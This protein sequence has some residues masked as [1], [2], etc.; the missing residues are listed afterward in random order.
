MQNATYFIAPNGNDSNSGRIDSPLATLA[1]ANELVKAGDTIY[2][3]GGTYKPAKDTITYLTKD[4]TKDAPIR[5]FAYQNENP[6]LDASHWTRRT[7]ATGGKQV[8]WQRGDYWHVKGI[9]ITGSSRHG[10]IA[11]SVKGSI[12]EDLNIHDN[13]QTGLGLFGDGTEDNLILGGDFYRN[14]DP[15]R[16]G[17]DAD[18]LGIGQG[19]GK[20]NVIR[21]V[22]AYHNS[23]DGIDLYA[24][25]DNITI[26]NT[27]AFGN[28]IDRW[29][30]GDA[31]D[32]DGAGFRLSS[33]VGPVAEKPDLAHIIRNNLA[34]DN[35]VRGFNYNGSLGTLQI[36]N[37]TS[38]NNGVS[39][40]FNR[41]NHR[42]RNNIAVGGDLQ[43]E[44]ELGVDDANNSWTLPVVANA[45]DF[46]SVDSTAAEGPRQADG[47][48]PDTDFLKLREDS[49]LI[50]AGIEIGLP[51]EGAAPDLGAFEFQSTQRPPVEPI[52][53]YN[54]DNTI[55][56]VV[57]DDS[58][59]GN[60]NS[61]RLING[62]REE[63][64]R[65]RHIVLNGNGQ[66]Q[67][68]NSTDINLGIHEERT[69]SLWFKVNDKS[70]TSRK[71]LLY[72]EGAGV[73]GL[74]AYI[75]D[76]ELY[77]GGWNEPS[78]ESNWAGSW[79]KTDNINS[80]QWHNVTLVLDGGEDITNNALTAYL[81][82]QEFGR[83][84]GSQLWNHPGG[85][86]LGR[87]FRGTKFH[88]GQEP[89]GGQGLTGS[90]DDVRIYNDALSANQV[91]I[92]ATM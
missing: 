78:R 3:R 16:K 62:V 20:G 64:E 17:Q 90:L 44:R 63:G 26:E 85:I 58:F 7:T 21:N 46:I 75:F 55:S 35:A 14:Y 6:I 52:A 29:N 1:K 40:A 31:F 65:G 11:E 23:D 91:E 15:F 88:D 18:G 47:S 51:F 32:G 83:S 59:A 9:E 57:T 22:R 74:N 48:L 54:F 86:G 80:N 45:D 76:D 87:V 13:D 34:W 42:L 27:W 24:F 2:M 60:N 67:I 8:I 92:L 81:D 69:V 79:I 19:S 84:E 43:I 5:L 50:D 53:Q 89:N 71:Q 33:D 38:Y 73:R 39:Y 12:F 37:N 56:N 28:G 72:E 36:L 4:G 49:D 70:L 10:Y 41:G 30:V 25:S 77:V 61:G 68:P 66:V 82:G